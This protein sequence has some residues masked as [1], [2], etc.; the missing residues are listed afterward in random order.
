VLAFFG[1]YWK[2]FDRVAWT[3]RISRWAGWI[4]VPDLRG[5]WSAQATTFRDGDA[6]HFDGRARIKQTAS[7]L[8]VSIRWLQSK[9]HSVSGVFQCGAGGEPELIYQYINHPDPG[10]VA[11]MQIHRGTAWLE[12]TGPDEFVGEYFSGRGR[13]QSGRL[14]LRRVRS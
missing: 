8:S 1:L 10:T 14:S 5:E 9:S 6:I 3:W 2:F 13:Q 11:T 4:D 12:L 7:R